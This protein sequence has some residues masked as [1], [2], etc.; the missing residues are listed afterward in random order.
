M[1]ITKHL[2]ILIVVIWFMTPSKIQG[3]LFNENKKEKSLF[4]IKK[5]KEKKTFYII[6]VERNDSI[7]KIVNTKTNFH[8]NCNEIKVGFLYDLNIEIIVV[9]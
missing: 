1:K 7:F 3:N 5:I 8:L 4:K 9:R 2:F 6:Y